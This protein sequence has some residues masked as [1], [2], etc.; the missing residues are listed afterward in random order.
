MAETVCETRGILHFAFFTLQ[1]KQ[2]ALVLP[3]A[4]GI[5]EILLHEL[6]RGLSKWIFQ[7]EKCIIVRG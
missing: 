5:L 6:V 3:Q 4:G 2:A 1:S 7:S